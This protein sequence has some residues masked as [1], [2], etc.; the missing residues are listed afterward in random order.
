LKC[1]KPNP[2]DWT[3]TSHGA[4]VYLYDS[5]LRPRKYDCYFCISNQPITDEISS[6]IRPFS[7]VRNRQLFSQPTTRRRPSYE[8]SSETESLG[9]SAEVVNQFNCSLCLIRTVRCVFIPCK[10]MCT[11][12]QCAEKVRQQLGS[13]CPICRQVFT[14]IWDVF[15]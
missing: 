15:L 14:E 8:E 10:H 1:S 3:P 5:K 12:V 2:G 9:L 11:C 7:L 4:F 13:V 6:H